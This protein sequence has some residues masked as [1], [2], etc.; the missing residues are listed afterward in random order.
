LAKQF[1]RRF[2]E[3]DQPQ[4]ITA[5]GFSVSEENFFLEINQSAIRFAC[6]GHVCQRIRTK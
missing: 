1:L 4:T 3:I 2:L 5:Y 6:G